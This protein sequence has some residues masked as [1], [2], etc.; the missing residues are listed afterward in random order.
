METTLK[1]KDYIAKCIKMA[2]DMVK[3]SFEHMW[4]DY[5]KEADVLYLSFRKPQRATK[6][7]ETD[8]GILIRKDGSRIVG[9]TI[10]D[11]SCR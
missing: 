7:I 9:M 6:T 5:D 10:L 11:A 1:K 3:L 2:S 4:V 8:N